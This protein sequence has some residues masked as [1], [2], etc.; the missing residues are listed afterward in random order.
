MNTVKHFTFYKICVD[1]NVNVENVIDVKK[2]MFGILL[3]AIVKM[4]NIQQLLWTIHQLCHEFIEPYD[5][6]VE[7]ELYDKT[8][9]NENK[10]T[11]KTQIIYILIAF[12][13][14]TAALLTAATTHCYL[15][16]YQEK[17][18]IRFHHTNNELKEKFYINKCIIKM[19]N[20]VKNINIKNRTY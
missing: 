1:V 14:V 13:L 17:Q 2:I 11:S 19:S 6:D 5:E 9:F 4:E 18:L 8:N 3:H 10:A 7:T 16:K 15:I 20:T 12:S